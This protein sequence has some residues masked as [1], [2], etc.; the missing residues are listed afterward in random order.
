MGNDALLGCATSVIVM[1]GL[2]G[3]VGWKVTVISSNFVA[4]MLILN[5]AMNIHVTVRFLQFKKLPELSKSEAV[6]E[7]S[8]N[9]VTYILYCINDNLRFFIF[10]I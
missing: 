4:L 1:I 3:L 10:S 6:F 7:A 2:L 5:M 9:D 8:K